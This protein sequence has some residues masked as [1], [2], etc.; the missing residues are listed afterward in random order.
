VVLLV[1]AALYA[2]SLAGELVYD[3]R[4]LI[5]RNPDIADLARLP[6]L[7][8]H[9]YWDFLGPRDAEYISYWRPLPAVL[10]ALV[11][12]V[13]GSY[14]AWFH[15]LCLAA[16][17]CATVAAFLLALRLSAS[18][19][20]AAATAALFA[21][22][23][24][25]VESVAW[26]SALNGP[27]S[28]ALVLFALE[29]FVAWRERGSQG[30][31]LSA[32]ALFALALLAKELAAAFLPLLLVVDRMRSPRS[33]E[34]AFAWPPTAPRRAYGPFLA[35]FGA[36]LVA[37]MLVFQSPWAGLERA[38]ELSQSA[39]RL[40]L[41]RLEVF[42]G[43]LEILTVPL[44]L[45]LLRPFRPHVALLD[46]QLV[47]AAVFAAVYAA[48]LV[49]SL[50]AGRRLA[51]LA[52]AFPL[53]GLLPALVQ[54]Q[55]LGLYPLSE[56][57]LYLPAFGFALGA[58]L[59][60]AQALPRRA[61]TAVVLVLAAAYA[62][63]SFARIGV[64]RDEETLFRATA[65]ASPRSV[66]VLATLG[67]VQLER[68][69]RARD[70]RMLA[71]AQQAFERAADLLE[72]SKRADTDVLADSRD[73]LNVNLGLAACALQA[74]DSSA[75]I[76][77]LE[78][79]A[80]RVEDIQAREREARALGLDVR[81]QPL[82]LER[83][84]SVLGSAQSRSG[85][86]EQAERSFARALEILPSSAEAFQNRGRMYVAQQRWQEAARDFEASARLRP[87]QPEDRLML[88]QVLQTLGESERAEALAQQ[89]LDELPLHPAPRI[90]LAVAAQTRGDSAGA[91]AWLDR[92]LELDP[93]YA[94]AWSHRARLLLQR[95]DGTAALSAF[96]NA[97]D[98]DPANFEALYELGG[99][100]L[101]Q[102]ALAEAQPYLARAY[103][104]AEPR[105][106]E[107]L[108]RNLLQMELESALL[109][110]LVRAD[111]ARDELEHA[112][113]W[114]DRLLA[115]TPDD[116]AA[117]LERARLLRRLGRDEEAL[118]ALRECAR[119]APASY[120]IRSELGLYLHSLGH[121]EEARTEIEQALTLEPPA[122][123]PPE[124]RESSRQRL[125]AL[126]E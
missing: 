95:G 97:L 39:L 12:P 1:T 118:A 20:V 122:S 123:F 2:R 40:A 79:L 107:P 111:A 4:L 59:L 62:A 93:R 125:R 87:G 29:R 47:R 76:V 88:A 5:A 71:E 6:A 10:H 99:A 92:A 75:A 35:V 30:W 54:V 85:E 89:L 13:G 100:L 68:A 105:H 19:W 52:L 69:D 25:Q 124:L 11:W 103:A 8:T 73:F 126:L 48:L 36:Y 42:G 49:A 65:A 43:A 63:R 119:R 41:L 96:R 74:G 101:A 46:P 115:R 82:E 31:P 50:R 66:G 81:A 98:L 23:P 120:E 45:N 60:L 117:A 33:G 18:T 91:L 70:P 15:L 55:S 38:G 51:V 113:A 116:G 27:L 109:R 14:P 83:V 78:D 112:L 37:R 34:P 58:A 90:V 21:L 3:D 17:L 84:Y 53:L 121:L 26:I 104:L 64:W 102:G 80:Q 72:E 67:R 56:R 106:R 94:L 86:F 108:R 77:M 114:A 61:A 32:A 24:A 57:F 7:F 16:H 44:T 22:H 110:E 28:G 9:G